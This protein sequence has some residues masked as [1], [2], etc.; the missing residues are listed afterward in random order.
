MLFD[1]SHVV[2]QGAGAEPARFPFAVTIPETSQPGSAARG[3]DWD[4]EKSESVLLQQ[5]QQQ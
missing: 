3:D 4:R 2:S 5:Q 1:Q